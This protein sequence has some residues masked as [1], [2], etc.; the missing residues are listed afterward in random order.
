MLVEGHGSEAHIGRM[1]NLS[2]VGNSRLALWPPDRENTHMT[3]IPVSPN[4]TF[5]LPPELREQL[6]IDR[7]PNPVFLAEE[8]EGGLLLRVSAAVPVRDVSAETLAGWIAEDEAEARALG[9]T[10]LIAKQ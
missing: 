6:G 2:R 4:G 1:G 5:T 3:S 9:L 8:A 10:D 7:I